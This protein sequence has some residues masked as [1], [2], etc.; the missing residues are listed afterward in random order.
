MKMRRQP[1]FDDLQ[2]REALRAKLSE[3]AGL[4][5]PPDGV[6]RRPSFSLSV[7]RDD[8]VMRHFLSTMDWVL[9]EIRHN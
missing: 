9:A 4:T 7:L 3:M 1:P 2:R 6:E 5:I 8:R